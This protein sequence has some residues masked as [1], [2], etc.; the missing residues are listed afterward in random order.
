MPFIFSGCVKKDDEKAFEI[1]KYEDRIIKET[2]FDD[3]VLEMM[4]ANPEDRDFS[5]TLSDED[6]FLPEEERWLKEFEVKVLRKEPISKEEYLEYFDRYAFYYDTLDTED[7]DGDGLPNWLEEKY[8]TNPLERDTDGDG[9]LDGYEVFSSMTN[10]S[11]KDSDNNGVEDGDED[12]DSDGLTNIEEQFFGSEAFIF[13]TDNDGLNDYEESIWQT[14]PNR[15]DTDEDGIYDGIEVFVTETNPLKSA[16]TKDG[17]K[18]GDKT[19]EVNYVCAYKEGEWKATILN[20]SIMDKIKTPE[21]EGE[22]IAIVHIKLLG[23]NISKINIEVESMINETFTEGAIS[24][25]FLLKSENKEKIDASIEFL[26]KQTKESSVLYFADLEKERSW[27]VQT[28]SYK[29]GHL[30]TEVFE[31]DLNHYFYLKDF[32]KEV[33]KWNDW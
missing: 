22:F 24:P 25:F 26:Y 33:E 11:E 32:E 8:H 20:Q 17:I 18:D 2:T 13:D 3:L 28:A 23:S 29:K 14:D 31:M 19:F 27:P 1:I 4:E 16:S 7:S 6:Q 10:P 15:Q 30:K 21:N 5:I 9:L 12:Y